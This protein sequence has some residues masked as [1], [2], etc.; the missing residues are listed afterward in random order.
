[1]IWHM[2][3]EMA[4]ASCVALNTACL[5]A[6]TEGDGWFIQNIQ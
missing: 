3:E 4:L 1:M 6:G 2:V 5:T